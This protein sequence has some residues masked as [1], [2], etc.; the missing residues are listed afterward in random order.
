MTFNAQNPNTS[1]LNWFS[2]NNLYQSNFV[3]L[4]PCSTTN[5]FSAEGESIQDVV[6]R[7]F[8]ISQQHLGCPNDFG[9]LC[10]AEKPDVCNWAQFSKYP[11][12]MYTKQGRSWNRDAATADTLVIS[13]S[14]DL[15]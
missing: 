3:D 10:I 12:F 15:L 6:S 9:W 8:Y 14:V 11:V 13:V 7:R 4:T 1:N 2:K 5:Y